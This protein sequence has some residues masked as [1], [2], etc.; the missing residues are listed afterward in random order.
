MDK[1]TKTEA[2]WRDLLDEA[3]FHV[4]RQAGTE[5]PF[6]GAH[7]QEKRVG[8]FSCICCGLALFQS[9]AKFESGCGWPGFFQPLEG[10][11][12]E[13]RMDTSYGSVRVEIRCSR[14]EAHLGHVFPDG[15]PPTGL[16]YCINS[17]SLDFEAT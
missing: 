6:S 4:T 7:N 15:P 10:A 16:R 12:L 5:A 14:C 3:T 2:Q 9:D 11:H 13:E 1:V 17:V 8:T